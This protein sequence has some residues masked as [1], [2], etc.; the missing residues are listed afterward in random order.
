MRDSQG[1]RAWD[2]PIS[3]VIKYN[4]M[5]KVERDRGFLGMEHDGTLWDNLCL[6]S[7]L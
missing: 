2:D 6:W 1:P 5:V 4:Q 3:N 7:D